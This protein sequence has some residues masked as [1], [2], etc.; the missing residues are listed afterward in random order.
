VGQFR[1]RVL[2][3][4]AADRARWAAPLTKETSLK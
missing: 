3:D 4:A 1:Q 2:N